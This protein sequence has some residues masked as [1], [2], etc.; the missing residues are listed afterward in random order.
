MISGHLRDARL[1]RIGAPQRCAS[2]VQSLQQGIPRGAHAEKFAAAHPQRSLCYANLRANRRHPK[3]LIN[4]LAQ[5]LFETKHYGSAMMSCPGMVVGLVGSQEMHDG[6]KHF[7]L[8]C[9]CDLRTRDEFRFGF[10]KVAGLPEQAL[11][12]C[13]FRARGT[14]YP[15]CRWGRDRPSGQCLAATGELLRRQRYQTPLALAAGA[16][17][18]ALA[19]AVKDHV[20]ASQSKS[21]EYR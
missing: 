19:A 15:V 4:A 16:L 12:P 10:R 14:E 18:H 1:R 21:T 2:F 9:S 7:L 3:F 11:K 8:Q 6:V 5:R 13:C 20:A 17:M